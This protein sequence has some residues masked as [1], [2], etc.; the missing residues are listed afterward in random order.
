MVA[1]TPVIVQVNPGLV[2]SISNS[3]AV[4]SRDTGVYLFVTI[5][6]TGGVITGGLF[7]IHTSTLS[8]PPEASVKLNENA[9]T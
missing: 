2:S 3:Y 7:L 1:S 5:F 4:K 8:W 9:N 6:G